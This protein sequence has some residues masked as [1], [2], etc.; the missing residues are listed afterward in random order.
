LFAALIK[1]TGMNFYLTTEHGEST[2]KMF[3]LHAGIKA[4]DLQCSSHE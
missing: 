3:Q 1:K 4:S 2:K